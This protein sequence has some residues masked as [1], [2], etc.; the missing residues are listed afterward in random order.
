[1][2]VNQ[3]LHNLYHRFLLPGY[4]PELN[5]DELVN[6]DVKTNAVSKHRPLNVNQLADTVEDYLMKRKN[7]LEQ[8]KKIF[9]WK[10][11]SICSLN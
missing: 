5:P 6:Q 7:D 8:V 9:S 4:S 10:T 11:C 2:L 3:F 1:M